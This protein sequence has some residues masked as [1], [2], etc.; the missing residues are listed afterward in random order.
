MTTI[1]DDLLA[2]LHGLGLRISSAALA[3]LLGEAD[4]LSPQDLLG[5]LVAQLAGRVS[6]G[7]R[8]YSLLSIGALLADI[9]LVA[10]A[11]RLFD[12]EKLL[13]RWR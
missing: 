5:A 6:L 9:A 12:R 1:S 4:D 7:W 8:F 11:A 3:D 13:T 2:G 10:L